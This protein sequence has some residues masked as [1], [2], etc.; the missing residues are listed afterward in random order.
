MQVPADEPAAPVMMR[1]KTLKY[2]EICEAGH[3]NAG[4]NRLLLEQSN[5]PAAKPD[6]ALR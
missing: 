3:F 5:E 6:F 1:T 4:P 2:I